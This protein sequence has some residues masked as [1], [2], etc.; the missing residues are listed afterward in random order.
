MKRIIIYLVLCIICLI[1]IGSLQPFPDHTNQVNNYDSYL[2]AIEYNEYGSVNHD[3]SK[4]NIPKIL[5]GFILFIFAYLTI[6]FKHDI[7][8]NYLYSF[9]KLRKQ[10]ENLLPKLFNSRLFAC[11]FSDF[12]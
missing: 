3:Y 7:P 2:G 4:L 12:K 9:V 5:E 8:K 11:S 6:G 10:K 1:A